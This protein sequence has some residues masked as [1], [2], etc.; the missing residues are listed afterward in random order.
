MQ[1]ASR[2]RPLTEA[3]LSN[4]TG[5]ECRDC[6]QKIPSRS[7]TCSHC[8]SKQVPK[9][10]QQKQGL[11]APLKPYNG[12]GPLP[13]AQ[14]SKQSLS[15]VGKQLQCPALLKQVGC[16]AA[17]SNQR[18]RHSLSAAICRGATSAAHIHLG[19]LLLLLPTAP[20]W[21]IVPLAA[22]H[23]RYNILLIMS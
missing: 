21:C 16:S 12:I 3:Q 10:E 15:N 13:P 17:D 8:N 22:A 11:L 19:L 2:K 14:N 18:H 1:A 23:H 9:S 20:D 5:K 4:L 6:G 7:T